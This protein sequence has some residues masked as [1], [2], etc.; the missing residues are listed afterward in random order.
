MNELI[1]TIAAEIADAGGRAYYAGGY[2][3]DRLLERESHDIDVEVHGLPLAD[4]ERLLSRHGNCHAVGRAFGVLKFSARQGEADFSLPRRESKSG[5]GHRGFTV[6]L[7]P[8]ITLEE[9]CSRRDFTINALLQDA[10]SGEVHDFFRGRE[11]LSAGILRHTSEAFADDPLRVY[12]LMQLAGR[13]E[14]TAAPETFAVCREMDLGDLAPERVFMEFEKLMLLAARPSCGMTAALEAGVLEFHPELKALVGCPQDP[15]WHPEGDVW[16]HTLLVLD[17]AAALRGGDRRRDLALM[18]G[19]LCHDFGKP[20]TTKGKQGRIVSPGHAEAGVALTRRFLGRM[21]EERDLLDEVELFVL[22]HL[23]PAEFY[24]VRDEI[25]DSAI[26]R[27]ALKVNFVDLVRMAK[28][29]HRGRGAQSD[30]E[31]EFPAGKWLLEKAVNLEVSEAGPVPLLMGRH[32]IERG[33]EP[34]PA[35]G[36]LLARAFEAQLDGLF[37]DLSGAYAWL[38]EQPECQDS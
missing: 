38:D 27:L 22:H 1:T 31:R 29:D 23:R 26:R 19:A 11:D 4:L 28:A 21:T 6:A 5:S 12:R 17:E 7:D 16:T 10:L 9:A 32:L 33:A 34:G 30:E 36:A 24:R 3:R 18:F 15:E 8:T 14:M 2:V 35:L 13:L 20:A 25:K 37:T